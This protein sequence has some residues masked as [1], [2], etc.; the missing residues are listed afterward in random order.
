[1]RTGQLAIAPWVGRMV[2]RVGNRPIMVVSQLI[3]ATGPL[4]FLLASKDDHG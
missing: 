1:M 2:D 3:T 4:F